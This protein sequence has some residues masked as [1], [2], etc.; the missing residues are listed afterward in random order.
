MAPRPPL[1]TY[2]NMSSG[3]HSAFTLPGHLTPTYG[4]A[5]LPGQIPPQRP[6]MGYSQGASGSLHGIV[7]TSSMSGNS[8]SPQPPFMS[9]SGS[10]PITSSQSPHSLPGSAGFLLPLMAQHTDGHNNQVGVPP[11]VGVTNARTQADSSNGLESHSRRNSSTLLSHTTRSELPASGDSHTA[12]PTGVSLSR[13][14]SSAGNP[15]SAS[16]FDEHLNPRVAPLGRLGHLPNTLMMGVK[17]PSP[18]NG[19]LNIMH[20]SERGTA[21]PPDIH[22]TAFGGPHGLP[23]TMEGLAHQGSELGPLNTL[24]DRVVF[25]SN[26]G[27][28]TLDLIR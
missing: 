16:D 7:N 24:H 10:L 15:K 14:P 22:T 21:T 5:W 13:P 12:V 23:S 25:V 19:S 3:G 4:P 8:V 9:L 20:S 17:P 1:Y 11:L 26:V 18:T 27:R 2:H 28:I 6:S